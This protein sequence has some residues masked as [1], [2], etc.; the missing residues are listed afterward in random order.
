[1]HLAGSP[2]IAGGMVELEDHPVKHRP[3][4]D[5]RI[6]GN[7]AGGEKIQIAGGADFSDAGGAVPG[8]SVWWIL[9]DQ[10]VALKLLPLSL[11]G[12]H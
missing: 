4:F 1:M 2:G 9:F 3:V 8:T 7:G 11:R 10:V 5:H 6:C 12:V